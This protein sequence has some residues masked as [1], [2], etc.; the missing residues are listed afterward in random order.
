MRVLLIRLSSFGDVVLTMAAAKAI[1][2]TLPHVT[3]AWA[4]E[5]PI[6][7]LVSGAPYVDEVFTTR[8]KRW[9]RSLASLLS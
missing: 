7:E 5:E 4:I 2:K 8:T 6:A 3:L 1:K 9:R